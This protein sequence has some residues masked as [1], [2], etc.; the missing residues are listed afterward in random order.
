MFLSDKMATKKKTKLLDLEKTLVA[1]C[2]S[3]TLCKSVV[4]IGSIVTRDR[5]TTKAL[6]ASETQLLNLSKSL[7]SQWQKPEFFIYLLIKLR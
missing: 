7:M 4:I 3:F 2:S 5:D 6:R 1:I